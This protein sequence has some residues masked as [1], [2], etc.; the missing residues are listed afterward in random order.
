MTTTKKPTKSCYVCGSNNW[1]QRSDGGW[2]CGWC[3]PNPNPEEEKLDEP[4]MVVV[5]DQPGES[6]LVPV[7]E[8]AP[9]VVKVTPELATDILEGYRDLDEARE[10]LAEFAGRDVVGFTGRGIEVNPAM[11]RQ[12][13]EIREAVEEKYSSEVL[14]LRDRVILGNKKLNAAWEQIKGMVHDTEEWNYQMECWHQG[15]EKLSLL[16][17]ELQARGYVDCLYIENGKKTK[18]CLLSGDDIGCRVCPSSRKYW[19]EEFEEL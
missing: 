1:W 11:L 2:C 9:S 7:T 4:K 17:T 19:E 3:H 5:S 18:K 12:A 14:A 13:I 16:C 8:P 6:H 15:N 10:A